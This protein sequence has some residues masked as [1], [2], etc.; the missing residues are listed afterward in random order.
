MSHSVRPSRGELE[1]VKSLIDNVF[2][3]YSY[4][5]EVERPEIL[6]GWRNI[7]EDFSVLEVEENTITAAVNPEA[8]DFE[9]EEKILTALLELEYL[10]K[11]D[12]E[13]V[14]KWQEL[15]KFMYVATKR[16]NITGSELEGSEVIE[17]RWPYI[18]DQLGQRVS[19]YDQFY[20]MNTLIIGETL[21]KHSEKT[22][23]EFLG[24][25]KSDVEKI[26]DNL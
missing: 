20:Y 26:G 5:L 1:K 6:L 8:G 23:G 15:L 22:L 14:F 9:L 19:E 16:S 7:E 21:A 2:Q 25:E 11:I 17:D 13:I 24:L 12:S 18:R 10:Q 3:S 4:A